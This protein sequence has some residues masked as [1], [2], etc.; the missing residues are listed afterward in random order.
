M[1]NLKSPHNL[2]QP[3]KQTNKKFSL[4][5]FICGFSFPSVDLTGAYTNIRDF[6]VGPMV[7]NPLPGNTG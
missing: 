2:K 1:V 7:R 4:G 3:T 5:E 6:A